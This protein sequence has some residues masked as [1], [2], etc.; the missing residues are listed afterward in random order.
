MAA[1][2]GAG[3][4]LPGGK[5]ELTGASAAWGLFVTFLPF[6][7]LKWGFRMCFSKQLSDLSSAEPEDNKF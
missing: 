4:L 3:G 2:W 1:L 7:P 6:R 5:A